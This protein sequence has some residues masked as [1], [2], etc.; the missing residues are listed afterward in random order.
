MNLMNAK[1]FRSKTTP[2]IKICGLTDVEQALG[3]A[4]LGA[5]AIGCVFFPKSPRHVSEEQA[6]EIC[7][8]LPPRVKKVGVFVNEPFSAIMQ[9]VERC[10]LTAV[11]L[12]GRESSELLKDL[13]RE[14]LL[15][16]KA[17]FIDREPFLQQVSD[18][19]AGAFLVEYGRGTLP[20][21]NALAWEWEQASGFGRKRPFIL[22]GGLTPEN[23][24]EAVS[25][26]LPD[27][28]DVSSGVES[29]PGVKDL[30]K[31]ESFIQAVSQ[32]GKFFSEDRETF[33][34]IF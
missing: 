34:G 25:A 33:I 5:N 32:C 28:V 22:A 16:I 17:L 26:C 31:V 13:G 9:K 1:R 12:H 7:S 19:T 27:A 30:G 20:G 2:Q 18:Y 15:V 14:N 3:C 21:G 23:V 29:A 24:V 8:A 11:Q 10:G 6:A 4:E